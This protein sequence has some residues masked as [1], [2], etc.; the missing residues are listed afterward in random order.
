[1]AKNVYFVD[2][3][4][5]RNNVAGIVAYLEGHEEEFTR[6]YMFDAKAGKWGHREYN[7][8][9]V[10]AA[11]SKKGDSFHEDDA[12]FTWYLLSKR[13]VLI[14]RNQSGVS[15]LPIPTADTGPGR[16]GYVSRIKIIGSHFYVCG[17]GRQVYRLKNGAWDDIAPTLA[18]APHETRYGFRDIDGFSEN[19][20]YA[21]GWQGEVFHFNGKK[22]TQ[23]DVPTNVDFEGVRCVDNA[24]YVCGKRGVLLI[25]KNGAWDIHQDPEITEHFWGIEVFGGK[26]YLS[27]LKGLAYF[28]GT[29]I[30]PM[31]T[32]LQPEVGGYRLHAK[33]GILWSFG[34]EDLAYFDEASWQRVICPDNV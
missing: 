17:F 29:N 26:V 1:M 23:I 14:K 4:V 16:R 34:H 18:V 24:I 3:F 2:G 11:Y 22:W 20:I 10:S 25:G 7:H 21:V 15:E 33:E 9:I 6:F 27:H 19:D 12:P 31:A 13:G 5:A 8:Q 30:R 32:G 28:D